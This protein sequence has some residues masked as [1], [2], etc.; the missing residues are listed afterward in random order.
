MIKLETLL[1]SNELMKTFWSRIDIR[2][3]DE[4]WPYTWKGPRFYGIT[5]SVIACATKHG[6]PGDL[7]TLHH[8]DNTPCCNPSHLY[9]GSAGALYNIIR[10]AGVPF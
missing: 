6:L 5:V 10:K 3:P 4:C 1:A 2:G 8:C 7:W 9:H